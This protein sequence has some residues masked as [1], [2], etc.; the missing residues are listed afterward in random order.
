MTRSRFWQGW[1]VVLE[2]QAPPTLLETLPDLVPPCGAF[3]DSTA[4]TRARFVWNL[5]RQMWIREPGG[6]GYC[7]LQT[8]LA[9]EVATYSPNGLFV[10]AGVVRYQ[11]KVL[12]LPGISRAGK[13]TL[14]ESLVRRGGTYYS[15]E[16]AVFHRD[17]TVGPYPRRLSLRSGPGH[18]QPR[19]IAAEQLGWQPHMESVPLGWMIDCR[20]SRRH[21]LRPLSPGQ[22]VLSLFAHAVAARTQARALL[23]SL[24][25]ALAGV[26]ALGGVR[27][28]SES[29]ADWIMEWMSA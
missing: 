27:D 3:C 1:G 12:V 15:D 8:A 11:G 7:E 29:A 5:D 6:Q 22:S 26:P 23:E 2:I 4:A 17:G 24:P 9:L 19:L 14:V 13:S 28:D 10:H 16:F 18:P 20:Y 25:R 21:F